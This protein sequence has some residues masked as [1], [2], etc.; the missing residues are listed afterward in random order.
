M[1]Y[2][3]HMATAGLAGGAHC[4]T[5]CAHKDDTWRR[6][7]RAQR[8]PEGPYTRSWGPEAYLPIV[9]VPVH[10]V[11]GMP[12]TLGM[13]MPVAITMGTKNT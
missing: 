13:G 10:I 12:M 1:G 5:T 8:R 7:K 2:G 3:S 6:R 11:T 4:R 9:D